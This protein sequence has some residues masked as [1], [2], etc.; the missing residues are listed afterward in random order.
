MAGK[1]KLQ[2]PL[3]EWIVAAVGLAIF[4]SVVSLM[5][6]DAIAGDHSP[7]RIAVTVDTIFPSGDGHLVKFR[8]MN[9]GGETAAEVVVEGELSV[10]GEEAEKASAT[11]DYLP[12]H[13]ERVGGFF[14][15][16]AP[17]KEALKLRATS[18]REP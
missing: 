7:P 9:S 2:I 12:G 8:A 18:Y 14:F 1:S 5:L 15:Q 10:P 6:Y 11:L 3:A 4:A 13:S 17:S 16:S